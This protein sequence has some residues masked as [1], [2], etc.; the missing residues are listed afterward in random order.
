MLY[1]LSNNT[2]LLQ[3]NI[4]IIYILYFTYDFIYHLHEITHIYY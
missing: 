1:F 3:V 4:L 2:Q